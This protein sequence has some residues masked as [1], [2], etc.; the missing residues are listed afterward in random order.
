MHKSGQ[1]MALMNGIRSTG[2]VAKSMMELSRE[3]FKAG[4]IDEMVTDSMASAMGEDELEEETE[5][6]VEKVLAECG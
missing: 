6:E 5:E 3:M 1:L 2:V 4:V